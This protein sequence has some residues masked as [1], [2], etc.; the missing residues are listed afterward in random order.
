MFADD[1]FQE[2]LAELPRARFEDVDVARALPGAG[3][4]HFDFAW[5]TFGRIFGDRVAQATHAV[6]LGRNRDDKV[7]DPSS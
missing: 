7:I 5:A 1:G 2:I 6:K 3:D 4:A